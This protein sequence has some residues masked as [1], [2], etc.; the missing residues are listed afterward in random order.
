M[1]E[2]QQL[3]IDN[4]RVSNKYLKSI[5]FSIVLSLIIAGVV[6]GL[7]LG[8][9]K[10]NK[11]DTPKTGSIVPIVVNTWP[12]SYANNDA[13][14]ALAN[15]GSSL[16]AVEKGCNYCE[17]NPG[18]CDFSVGYG[19]SPNENG[20]T[21]LDALIMYGPTHQVG[22][23]G[24]LKNITNAI[25]VARAVMDYTYH[26]LLVGQDATNFAVEVGFNLTDLT[27]NRT[28]E[29]YEQWVANGRVPNHWKKPPPYQPNK[30]MSRNG[31]FG[32]DTVGM[33]SVDKTGAVSA[34]VSTNGMTWKVPGR[35][36]DSPIVG[37]G[38][39]VDNDIGASAATG[40]G[41]VMMRFAPTYRA[42]MNM[43]LGMSPTEACK[44]AIQ[45]IVK[46][47]PNDAMALVAVDKYG[48]HGGAYYGFNW[49]S[50][51]YQTEDSNGPQIVNL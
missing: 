11:K 33:V 18:Y 28:I 34:G 32:H 9:K 16:D 47:Y 29:M 30:K 25:S 23:V 27:T 36:G 40:N 14:L 41:D 43:G 10:D 5:V 6:L 26:T 39:Y 19:G 4:N 44:N 12:W 17:L 15:N 1:K 3:L 37:A 24:C 38:A 42:V 49:F 51:T 2:D 31:D 50:Y 48:N 45:Y 35:V 13:W 22:S 46:Y 21:T 20:E 7:V 8:L